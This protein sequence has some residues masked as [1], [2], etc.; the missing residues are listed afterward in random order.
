MSE[1]TRLFMDFGVDHQFYR[2]AF[3]GLISDGQIVYERRGESLLQ[4]SYVLE[5]QGKKC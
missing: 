5:S 1:L 3:A 4:G 2:N